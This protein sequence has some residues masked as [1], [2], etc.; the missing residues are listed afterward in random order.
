MKGCYSD[1]ETQCQFTESSSSIR[2]YLEGMALATWH[3]TSNDVT[4]QP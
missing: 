3:Y 1:S 4:V 2:K